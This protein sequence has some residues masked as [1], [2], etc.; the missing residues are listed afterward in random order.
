MA[1]L[2][3][4]PKAVPVSAGN[5]YPSC[6]AYFY[7]AG[8]TTNITTYTTA[9]LSV[10][11]ANPVVAD[12]NGVFAAIYI[13]EA[14]NSTYRL[15]IKTSA[16]VLVYDEDNIPSLPSQA[17][18]GAA[19]WPQTAA[20]IAAGVTPTYY[21]Y[22]P[23]DVRRYGF[24]SGG[25]ASTNATALQAALNTGHKVTIPEGAYSV[26]AQSNISS[27]TEI[28]AHR[29]AVIT[30]TSAGTPIL[31]GADVEDVLIDGGQWVG[32]NT[33]SAIDGG[34]GGI[35]YI[36][37]R[38][39]TTNGNVTI[40][41]TKVSTSATAGISCINVN[42][43][44]I[45]DNEVSNCADYGILASRSRNFH[46]E[47]N[48]I[49]DSAETGAANTYAISATGDD[50]GGESQKRC[51]ISNN[52]IL[53]FASWDGI[54]SHDVTSLIISG[55]SIENTRIGIDVG[56]SASTNVITDLVIVNNTIRLTSTDN[57]SAAAAVHGGILVIGHASTN[58]Q[59]AV[60]ANNI[61]SNLFNITGAT[62]SGDSAGIT[63]ENCEYVSITGN[64]IEGVGT[65]NSGRVGIYLLGD[66][67]IGAVT[68]NVLEGDM[69]SGGIRLGT[70]LSS[71]LAISGN[72]ILQDSGANDAI[73]V[74]AGTVSR[75]AIGDNA[76]N[77]VPFNTASA[78]TITHSGRARMDGIVIAGGTPTST[79]ESGQ[80]G[81][82]L[83][84][85]TTATNGTGEAMKA[86]VEG[87]LEVNVAGTIRKIPFVKD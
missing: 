53:N 64:V 66:I 20:E 70:V 62:L 22:E 31:K 38:G 4:L 46:I 69:S 10:A 30:S 3:Q 9:A 84:T 79:V 39:V 60:I 55:N 8:T 15:Q 80:I 83:T 7:Q 29:N 40:C 16:D 34:N 87:Y 14:V 35:I 49:H 73:Y 37:N 75:L 45:V 68:G 44:W 5:S 23:G 56:H 52:K 82:G 19:L 6:K 12:A 24:V 86:N 71:A 42:S 32:T 65:V 28:F 51:S 43:L 58:V 78:P 81:I 27:N 76:T 74:V 72:A 21:Y 67:T 11:H 41:N 18:I 59:R 26:N 63:A 36:D 17:N 77:A 54:M 2:F 33:T 13:N 50:A 1:S 48:Y 47:R 57:W 25:S 85:D 61:I